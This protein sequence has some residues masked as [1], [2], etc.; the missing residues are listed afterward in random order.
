MASYAFKLYAAPA[1]LGV[2]YN[3]GFNHLVGDFVY[4]S[5]GGVGTVA[6][7]LTMA[8][9]CE[10]YGE[11]MVEPCVDEFGVLQFNLNFEPREESALELS[12][13]FDVWFQVN[14]VK[15]GG[16]H[17]SGPCLGDKCVFKTDFCKER[18]DFFTNIH[19]VFVGFENMIFTGL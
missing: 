2:N 6:N 4:I 18:Y 10:K 1:K 19:S 11:I 17:F 7:R 14:S 3:S 8:D 5:H 13:E 15:Y 9:I 16:M 12:V